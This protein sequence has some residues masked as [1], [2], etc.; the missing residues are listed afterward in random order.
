MEKPD[1]RLKLFFISEIYNSMTH[2]IKKA[3]TGAVCIFALKLHI[4]GT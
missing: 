4:S 1:L 2:E 3:Y